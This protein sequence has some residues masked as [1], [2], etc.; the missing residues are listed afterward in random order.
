VALHRNT[1][2]GNA[3]GG[4]VLEAGRQGDKLTLV[5]NVIVDNGSPTSL[6]G[7]VSI[8]SGLAVLSFVNNTVV[9]NLADP[10]AVGAASGVRCSVSTMQLTVQNSIVYGNVGAPPHAGCG[11][12]YSDIEGG[13]AGAGN[14]AVDPLLDVA[15]KPTSP[16]CFDAGDTAAAKAATAID[17]GGGKR[18]LGNAVDLGAYEVK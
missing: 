16:K 17:R 6:A 2:T 13:A 5:D 7:G 14:I 10:A 11:F 8:G 9:K 18:V 3:R 12:S 1:I 4:V 15:W